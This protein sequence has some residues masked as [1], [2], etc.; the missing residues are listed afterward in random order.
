MYVPRPRVQGANNGMTV[1]TAEQVREI[2]RLVG[3]GA[4]RTKVAEQFGVS[5]S[6]IQGITTRRSWSW[7]PDEPGLH[8][9]TAMDSSGVEMWLDEHGQRIRVVD[10]DPAPQEP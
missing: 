1:L 8:D 2:R 5:A 6:T 7:L 10:A 9:P 4:R 3:H